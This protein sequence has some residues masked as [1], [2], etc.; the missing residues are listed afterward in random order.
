MKH[1]KKRRPRAGDKGF[2]SRAK[3]TRQLNWETRCGFDFT[4]IVGGSLVELEKRLA[5]L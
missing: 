4:P 2:V 5:A 3:G 1:Q